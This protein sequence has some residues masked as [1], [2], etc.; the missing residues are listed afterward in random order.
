[1][2][3]AQQ[4]AL[5]DR[6]VLPALSRAQRRRSEQLDSLLGG[7]N[8]EPFGFVLLRSGQAQ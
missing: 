6:F 1:M 2:S 4:V 7:I 3:A 8:S 5:F